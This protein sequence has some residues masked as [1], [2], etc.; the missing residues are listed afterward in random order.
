MDDVGAGAI[1]PANEI[2][3]CKAVLMVQKHLLED[4]LDDLLEDLLDDLLEDLRG[5]KK[6]IFGDAV[7]QRYCG[8]FNAQTRNVASFSSD[9]AGNRS[10][11]RQT[12]KTG[13][14]VHE[15]ENA[16]GAAR[17]RRAADPQRRR[18]GDERQPPDRPSRSRAAA[19]A[20]RAG[21]GEP[22]AATASPRPTW[23]KS[24]SHGAAGRISNRPWRETTPRRPDP[25]RAI[26]ALN[27]ALAIRALALLTGAD[28]RARR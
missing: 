2:A 27:P 16:P 4:L 14:F 19:R 17:I 22:V 20:G 28:P 11:W 5:L 13:V 26:A 15:P 9:L 7:F 12:P 23:P 8:Q 10:I 6:L 1:A 3:R 21:A 18:R 25:A 24:V